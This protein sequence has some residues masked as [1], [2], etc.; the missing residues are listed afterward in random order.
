MSDIGGQ[1]LLPSRS[2]GLAWRPL[3]FP[4]TGAESGIT[5]AIF[6]SQRM[7]RGNLVCKSALN[8]ILVEP[9]NMGGSR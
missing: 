4:E 3:V 6:N 1:E 9:P 5:Q 8:P 7:E 2:A